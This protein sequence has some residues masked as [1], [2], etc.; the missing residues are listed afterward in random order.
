M[1]SIQY[2][3]VNGEDKVQDFDTN[4]RTKLLI[5][6]A[7]FSRPIVAVYENGNVITKTVRKELAAFTCSKNVHARN[8]IA[9]L[10]PAGH[11]QK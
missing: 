10:T 1:Y 4:T 9:I 7:Q 2:E 5:H 3:A 11:V 8:F 6:L